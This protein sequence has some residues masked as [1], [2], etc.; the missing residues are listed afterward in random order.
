VEASVLG[1]ALLAAAAALVLV[2]AH[3]PTGG[4]VGLLGIAAFV[5]GGLLVEM[6]VPV[7]VAVALLVGGFG[8]FVGDRVFRAQRQERV[9]T[10]WEELVG[11]VGE[12]RAALDPVGQA[13][14]EG[15]LWTARVP[16]GSGPLARGAK[17]RITSVE[18]LT[19]H[20]EPLDPDER[21]A[22]VESPA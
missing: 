8:L 19:L 1:I 22:G 3:L 6:P 15:A 16:D 12:V 14:V 5:A 18:G 11:S 21:E 2:E 9:M 7:I 4:L 10:G 20:V 13:L 17:V